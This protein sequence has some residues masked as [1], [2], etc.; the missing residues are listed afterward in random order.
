MKNKIITFLIA[1][2]KVAK[3]LGKG[4]SAYS[5][6]CESEGKKIV[7]KQIHDEPCPYYDFGDKFEVEISAYQQLKELQ[8]PMP[9]LLGSDVEKRWIFKEYICGLT[10]AEQLASGS[11]P[12]RV[13]EQ[14]FKMAK[15]A[16]MAGINLDYFPT[17][18]VFR[19]DQ[20][21]YI[22]YEIN[23][24]SSKWNLVNWGLYYWLNQDGMRQFLESGD[25]R[26]IN[27]DTQKGIPIKNGF[28][29]QIN[30]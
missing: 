7:L 5:W 12:G 1:D 10:S 18:F 21:F 25:A 24:Y 23:P 17:N 20:L 14:L 29:E 4:K 16:S 22:D 26:F 2:Y 15:I 30:S 11:I 27:A 8:V 9:T 19:A 3:L 28:E 6:L 13:Y